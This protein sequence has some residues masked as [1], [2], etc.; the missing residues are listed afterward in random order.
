MKYEVKIKSGVIAI[1]SA[2]SKKDFKEISKIHDEMSDNLK[3]NEKYRNEFLAIYEKVM[4]APNKQFF[5]IIRDNYK[6]WNAHSG[7]IKQ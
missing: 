1:V 5:N 4:G 2:L 3:T 7:R 6:V